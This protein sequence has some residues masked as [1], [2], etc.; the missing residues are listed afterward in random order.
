[1][2]AYCSDCYIVVNDRRC[3]NVCLLQDLY[4]YYYDVSHIK[5]Y[6]MNK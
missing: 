1:M 2:F 4:K 3:S 5:D 6:G